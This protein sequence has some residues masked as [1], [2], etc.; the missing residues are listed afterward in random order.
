MK[1]ETGDLKPPQDETYPERQESLGSKAELGKCGS[2][3]YFYA[4]TFVVSTFGTD[5]KGK[6][7][8]AIDR[9][10][11]CWCRRFPEYVRREEDDWCGEW[12]LRI[13]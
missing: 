10:A 13:T 1:N 5:E 4:H 8:H 12:R 6:P 11:T 9:R 3:G 2:C 7:Q